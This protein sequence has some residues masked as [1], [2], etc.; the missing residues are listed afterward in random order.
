MSIR[1]KLETHFCVFNQKKEK[2]VSCNVSIALIRFGI[3]LLPLLK[4][5]VLLW[6]TSGIV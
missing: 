3:F 5:I 4:S 2:M 1:N 6:A